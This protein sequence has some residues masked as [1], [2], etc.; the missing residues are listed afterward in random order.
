MQKVDA[1]ETGAPATTRRLQQGSHRV[2][3]NVFFFFSLSS[4]V[5]VCLHGN[6]P[7]GVLFKNQEV[8]VMLIGNKTG[9]YSKPGK[10]VIF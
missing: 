5:S 1:G 7:L 6:A 3:V 10:V 2:E 4:I 9:L 8:L